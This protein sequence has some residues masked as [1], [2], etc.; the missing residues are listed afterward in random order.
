MPE[1]RLTNPTLYEVYPRSFLDTD[2]DGEGDLE[3]VIAK[4]P[5]IA[6]LGVDAIWLAPIYPSPRADGGYD[7]CDHRA[8]DP[9]YGTLETFD[10][11]VEAAETRGLGIV[12]DMVLNHTS[13]RHPWFQAALDGDDDA[14]SRYI[15]H[16]PNPDGTPP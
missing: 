4:L 6:S 14:A 15:F 3:G 10:R 12:M 7:V 13:D 1:R 11:L 5:Y 8:V 2:G 16:D 9:R